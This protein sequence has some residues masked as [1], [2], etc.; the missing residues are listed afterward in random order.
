MATRMKISGE[1]AIST[2]ARRN[3][4]RVAAAGSRAS[5]GDGARWRCGWKRKLRRRRGINAR[6]ESR[7]AWPKMLENRLTLACAHAFAERFS[8]R[9]AAFCTGPAPYRNSIDGVDEMAPALLAH[10]ALAALHRCARQ[11]ES[12]VAG[13]CAPDYEATT[14]IVA[15]AGEIMTFIS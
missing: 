6:V 1:I 11:C 4:A 7:R 9:R 8:C 15:A 13:A 12:N 14:A 3:S 2:M 5:R 10:A